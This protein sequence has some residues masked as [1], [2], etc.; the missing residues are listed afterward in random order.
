MIEWIKAF[1]NSHPQAAPYAIALALAVAGF[2]IPISADLVILIAATLAATILKGAFLK[3]YLAIFLGSICAAYIAYFQG[4]FLGNYLLKKKF[5]QK[6]FPQTKLAKINSYYKKYSWA[7]FIIGR[8]IPFGF[9]NALF[10]A[11]GLSKIPFKSFALRD[12]VGCLIWSFTL[13]LGLFKLLSNAHDLIPIIKKCNLV[14]F[15]ILGL[16]IIILF[17]YKRNKKRRIPA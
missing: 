2:N 1:I 9:R 17:W 16:S 5:F 10:M 8:F 7:T 14:I 12:A 13:Y 6:L 15:S 11:T 3:L 4:R